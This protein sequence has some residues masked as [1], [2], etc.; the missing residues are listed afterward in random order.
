MI[1]CRKLG[2]QYLWVD[3]LCIIQDSQEDWVKEAHRMESIYSNM[4]LTISALRPGASEG[5]HFCDR[6]PILSVTFESPIADPS[7][8]SVLGLRLSPPSF[9]SEMQSSP[10]DKR[11]W[12][13][14][15]RLLSKATLHYGTLP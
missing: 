15:E 12:V 2:I 7:F 4:V 10:L 8:P 13:F 9:D 3:A 6:P 1:V 14:Q 11:G 5:G